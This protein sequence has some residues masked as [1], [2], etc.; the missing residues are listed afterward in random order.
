M[1][2]IYANFK[3]VSDIVASSGLIS[4]FDQVQTNSDF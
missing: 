1:R 3:H 4:I 2:K